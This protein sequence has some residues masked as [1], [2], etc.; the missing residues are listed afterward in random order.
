[1]YTEM[2]TEIIGIKVGDWFEVGSLDP[3]FIL[4]FDSLSILMCQLVITISI[5]TQIYSFYYLQDDPNIIRF[6]AYLSLFTF[7][8]LILVTA[9][10]FIVF[11][12]G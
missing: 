9:D 3:S 8:M 2:S 6:Q 11:F 12:L 4:L 5:I 7:F 1:M 10:N